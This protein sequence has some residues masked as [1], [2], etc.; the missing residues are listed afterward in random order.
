MVG[1]GQRK[2][3]DSLLDVL[4]GDQGGKSERD[5][6]KILTDLFAGD[7]MRSFLLRVTKSGRLDCARVSSHEIFVRLIYAKYIYGICADGRGLRA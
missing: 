3:L 2:I 6:S 7:I 5:F 1:E 4:N